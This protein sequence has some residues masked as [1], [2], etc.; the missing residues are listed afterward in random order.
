MEC[1]IPYRGFTPNY[2]C[3]LNC[4][5]LY[6]FYDVSINT[7]AECD[8]TCI[9]CSSLS[10]CTQ[11]QVGYNLFNGYC[12]R[13]CYPNGNIITFAHP[14]GGCVSECP[15]DYFGEKSNY[16]CTKNCGLKMFGNPVSHLCEVCPAIC[17]SC[18]SLTE[19]YTC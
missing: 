16:T 19:C 8:P 14:L 9:I 1:P 5:A 10:S 13:N 18:A 6:Y 17:A 4:P 7:C 11:C 3:V 15:I 12:T 2:T